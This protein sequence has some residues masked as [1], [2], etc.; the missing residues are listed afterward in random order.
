MCLYDCVNSFMCVRPSVRLSVCTC[1]SVCVCMHLLS[2]VYIPILYKALHGQCHL[3]VLQVPYIGPLFDGAIVDDRILPGLVRAT[4]IT[5]G[6]ILRLQKP[7]YK[8]LYPLW[9]DITD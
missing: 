3:I 5:A 2:S 6:R 1:V 9:L 7:Y 8:S 4:A